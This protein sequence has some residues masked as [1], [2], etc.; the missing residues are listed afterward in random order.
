MFNIKLDNKVYRLSAQYF[1]TRGLWDIGYLLD[2]TFNCANKNSGLID[3]IRTRVNER[4]MNERIK[5]ILER[6]HD[7]FEA[8]ED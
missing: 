5:K 8:L 3:P 6:H 7:L 2:K 4:R 1:D